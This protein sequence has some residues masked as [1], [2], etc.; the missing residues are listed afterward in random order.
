MVSS[1]SVLVVAVVHS[2]FD[3]HARVNETDDSSRY[4]DEVRVA[5]VGRAS[6]AGKGN[7]S[8]AKEKTID[9]RGWGG[10]GQ[11]R[12]TSLSLK[13]QDEGEHH[14]VLTQRHQ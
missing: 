14:G 6:K 12:A 1:Q 8:Q 2:N 9:T 13:R 7:I 10:S 4:A 5:T 11:G 3:A